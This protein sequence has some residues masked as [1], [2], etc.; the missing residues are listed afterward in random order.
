MRL[1]ECVVIYVFVSYFGK[2]VNFGI[3][4]GFWFDLC[5]D[6]KKSRLKEIDLDLIV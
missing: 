5:F 1:I 3:D 2:C 4:N 6:L